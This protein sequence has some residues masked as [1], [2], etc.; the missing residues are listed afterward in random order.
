[1]AET[2][3]M[4]LQEL[5]YTAADFRLQLGS[6]VCD[7]GVAD[8]IDGSLQVT[9]GGSGLDLSVAQGAAFI[10]SDVAGQGMYSVYNDAPVTL[11]ATTADATNP[12]IDQVIATVNDSQ[13]GGT[14]DDWVLSV[15]AGTPTVGATLTN[16]SGATALPDRSIR[17]GYVLVPAL[18]AGPFVDATHILD[19]R[20]EFIACGRSVD[21]YVTLTASAAT[22]GI[23]SGSTTKV[24]LATTTHL[25]ASHFT[26]AASVIT[27]LKAGIYDFQGFVAAV[28]TLSGT[29]TQTIGV[30]RNGTTELLGQTARPSTTSAVRETAGLDGYPLNAGDTLQL[31]VNITTTAGT[32]STVQD[33]ANG[34]VSRLTVRKVG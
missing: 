12:R 9:T 25:D 15:L 20:T 10:N 5:C 17:L 16:L 31:V 1:M 24:N 26:V 19:A 22:T 21:P 2:Q 6:I 29:A 7:E 34:L 18:F 32:V 14:D 3:P 30:G 28:G 4:M 27:V 8:V 33:A 23:A 11:T 13:Q